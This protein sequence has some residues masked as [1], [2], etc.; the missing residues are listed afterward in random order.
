MT[1]HARPRRRRPVR[2]SR[3]P[4]HGRRRR[5]RGLWNSPPR[6]SSTPAPAGQERRDLPAARGG[7][8]HLGWN[9]STACSRD[10]GLNPD[11]LLTAVAPRLFGHR[12]SSDPAQLLDPRCCAR[13][14]HRPRQR[15][16]RRAPTGSIST[17]S[18]QNRAPFAMPVKDSFR[19]TSGFGMRWG[20]MHNGTDFAAPHRHADLRHRRRG[21][22]RRPA[23]P[24]ATV[25]L[26]Q[27]SSTS[28][29]LRPAMPISTRFAST[30]AKGFSPRTADR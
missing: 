10:A 3:R 29:A 1:V 26:N 20:R 21:R 23:G 19:Y 7:D 9:R 25:R 15:D 13:C 30:W 11:T 5:G 14:G 16:P 6:P 24:R 17:G 12:R 22:D 28:S 2:N 8:D 4:R 27:G 18:P